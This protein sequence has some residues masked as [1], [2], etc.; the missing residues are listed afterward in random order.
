M[1]YWLI[2]TPWAGAL[3]WLALAFADYYL[4]LLGAELYHSGVSEHIDYS[5]SYELNPLFQKEIDNR[6]KLSPKFILRS[7]YVAALLYALWYLTYYFPAFAEGIR[8]YTILLGAVVLS[9]VVVIG[10]HL[11]NILLFRTMNEKGGLV[12][13]IT[14]ARRLQ[15]R[16]WQHR[17]GLNGGLF[18]LIFALTGEYFFLGGAAL[19]FLYILQFG[20]WAKKAQKSQAQPAA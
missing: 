3:L 12:G 19:C 8:V 11:N 20:F 14:Y 7:S 6:T 1:L 13:K 10:A 17:W 15:Y 2:L 5:G 4:T 9:R 16:V 18:L